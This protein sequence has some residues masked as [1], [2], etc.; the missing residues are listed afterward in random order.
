M[1]R[2]DSFW[3]LVGAL[4]AVAIM[5]GARA[6]QREPP[7]P[8]VHD[9]TIAQHPSGAA[10][11]L[12]DVTNKLAA[13]LATDGGSDNDWKLLAESYEYLGRKADA[14]AARAHIASTGPTAA[15]TSGQLADIADTLEKPHAKTSNG[16]GGNAR[17]N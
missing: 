14:D 3:F 15:P 6:W 1:S 7:T 12:D 13:R 2:R 4:V 16:A 8:P 10:G 17:G 11:S 9:S 5:V